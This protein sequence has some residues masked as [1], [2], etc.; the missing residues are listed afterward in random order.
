MDVHAT[1]R[2]DNNM[3]NTAAIARS[4]TKKPKP[5]NVPI[6]EHAIDFESN[7]WFASKYW[8]LETATGIPIVLMRS[9]IIKFWAS[10]AVADDLS[11]SGLAQIISGRSQPSKS[12]GGPC[13][14][15][16]G[17]TSGGYG[18]IKIDGKMLRAHRA[19]WEKM[20]GPIPDGLHVLHRCDNRRCINPGHLFLGSNRDN[21]IDK[22]LKGHGVTPHYL[23]EKHPNAK[24]SDSEAREIRERALAGESTGALAEE[25]SVSQ[26]AVS[27]IKHSKTYRHV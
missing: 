22:T 16:E 14:P 12:M 13:L 24:L 17:A 7:Y 18:N 25:F 27:L 1:K 2:G 10:S 23:G 9:G 15:W 3:N 11:R 5:G 20:H 26:A 4:K 19:A 8:A 21:V 6:V